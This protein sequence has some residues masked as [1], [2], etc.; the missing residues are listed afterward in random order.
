MK[1]NT[2]LSTTALILS[3]T[4]SHAAYAQQ[5]PTKATASPVAQPYNP[6]EIILAKL[7]PEKLKYYRDVI[8]QLQR[9]N[10][11]LRKQ[12]IDLEKNMDEMLLSPQFNKTEYLAK[13]AQ[14]VNLYNQIRA[15]GVDAIG[16]MAAQFTPEERKI[17]ME[18]RD[19]RRFAP[20]PAPAAKDAPKPAVADK[21]KTAATSSKS[22][23]SS[24]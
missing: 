12:A 6:R 19:P 11:P 1:I 10:S 4:L 18:L 5:A 24:K 13:D 3:L 22:K 14:I 16:T 9:K 17:L 21:S 15:N 8:A 7:P 2:L 20:P 23:T